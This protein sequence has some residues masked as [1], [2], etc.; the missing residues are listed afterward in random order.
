MWPA[1]V[2]NVYLRSSTWQLTVERR[3]PAS[4]PAAGRESVTAS[5]GATENAGVENTIQSKLQE[6][7]KQE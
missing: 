2:F 4:D 7:K 5:E 1:L 6:W 3:K